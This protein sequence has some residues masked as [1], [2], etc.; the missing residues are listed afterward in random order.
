MYSRDDV[1]RWRWQQVGIIAGVVA[2]LI[3]LITLLNHGD[4]RIAETDSVDGQGKSATTLMPTTIL[5][6]ST[7]APPAPSLAD[8]RWHGEIRLNENSIN[9][10]HLPPSYSDPAFA[11]FDYDAT[12]KILHVHTWSEGALWSSRANPTRDQ[13]SNQL[14]THSLS[15]DEKDIE[16]PQP[17]L[18]LCLQTFSEGHVAFARVTKILQGALLTNVVVWTNNS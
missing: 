14:A 11:T 6:P 3:A 15:R 7:T 9:L 1:H 12:S 13:C 17:G 4:N 5:P 2:A 8:V 18:G 10:D 16:Q